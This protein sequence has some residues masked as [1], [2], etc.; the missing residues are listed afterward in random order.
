MTVNIIRY[1]MERRRKRADGG[2]C[3][4]FQAEEAFLTSEKVYVRAGVL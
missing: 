2:L 1:H 3:V 4:Y